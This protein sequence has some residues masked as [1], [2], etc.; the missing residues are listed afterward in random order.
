MLDILA[1]KA[2]G[3]LGDHSVF[4]YDFELYQKKLRVYIL[5]HL[6]GLQSLGAEVVVLKAEPP[7]LQMLTSMRSLVRS[8]HE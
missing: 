6:H 1:G 5:S 4:I 8:L 7:L 3:L 2:P